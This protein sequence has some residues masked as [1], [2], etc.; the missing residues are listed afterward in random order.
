MS[1]AIIPQ[2]CCF[3]CAIVANNRGE[4]TSVAIFIAAVLIIAGCAPHAP[5]TP[6]TEGQEA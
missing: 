5:T 1:R 2:I 6:S 3:A 4:P